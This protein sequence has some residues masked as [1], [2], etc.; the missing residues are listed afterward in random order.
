MFVYA[1][2]PC[3]AFLSQFLQ[4][5]LFSRFFTIF[6]TQNKAKWQYNTIYRVEENIYEKTSYT[7][8]TRMV[9]GRYGGEPPRADISGPGRRGPF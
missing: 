4:K 1:L 3:L 8:G 5:A 6:S 9:L 2:G 7:C